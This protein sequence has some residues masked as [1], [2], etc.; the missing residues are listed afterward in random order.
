MFSLARLPDLCSLRKANVRT[1]HGNWEPRG[2]LAL[3]DHIGKARIMAHTPALS[4]TP[5][6]ARTIENDV[7]AG[8]NADDGDGDGAG[9]GAGDNA[10]DGDG[11]GDADADDAV[12]STPE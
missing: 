7:V 1:P 12:A 10:G 6:G 5:P 11:D 3:L 2:Q 4:A 8:D 9:D